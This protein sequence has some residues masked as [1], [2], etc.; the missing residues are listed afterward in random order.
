MA[1]GACFCVGE[2]DLGSWGVVRSV[3]VAGDGESGGLQGL[4]GKLDANDYMVEDKF[5][6]CLS[7]WP[8]RVTLGRLLS[9]ARGL[10]FKPRRGG[11]PSG[12][13]KEWGLSPKAKVQVLHTAQLDVTVEVE[14]EVK[15][16]LVAAVYKVFGR[17][18]NDG[19]VSNPTHNERPTFR[20]HGRQRRQSCRRWC[21]N[22]SDGVKKDLI[23][24]NEAVYLK[25]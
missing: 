6:W 3:G 1:N 23:H 19:I 9:H 18:K 4:A 5:L 17:A 15:V 22:D 2:S 10:G 8:P 16:E 25:V 20:S 24:P 12:A 14:V 11:F 7:E 13:K 21:S